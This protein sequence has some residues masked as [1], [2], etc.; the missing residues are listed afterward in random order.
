MGKIIEKIKKSV[1]IKRT[2][3]VIF[4]IAI[5]VLFIALTLWINSLNLN[6]IDFTSEKLYTL[7]ET[8]KE[9]V[10]N[11]QNDVN[12]YFIGYSENDAI[13]DL[14]KQ[15]HNEN[16]KINIE[17]TN[18][19][20]RPDLVEKYGIDNNSNG[21]IVEG[22][23]KSKI[24]ST[25]DF[26]TYDPKTYEQIDI[27]EEKLTNSILYVVAEKIPTVYFLEG[28]SE[29]NISVNMNYL[30]MYLANE[31]T[32]Y[33]TLNILTTGSIPEDCD[34][35]IIT[36]PEKD[37]D[38][39]AAN[40]ITEYINKGGNILWFNLA[41]TEN[42]ELPN[43]N[44]I[45][46]LYG[47]K[48]FEVGVINE[49]DNSRMMSGAPSIIIPNVGYNTITKNIPSALLINASKINFVAEEE[50]ESLKVTKNTLL[51]A[52]EGAF[53]RTNFNITSSSKQTGEEEGPFT[54]GA[55]MQKKIA[56]ANTETGESEKISKL[57]I[58]GEN[59]FIS[60]Y[61]LTQTSSYPMISYAYT[62]DLVIDSIAYLVDR[63]E[64]IVIRKDTNTVNYTATVEQ[65]NIIQG[66]IFGVPVV[67]ILIG[68]LVWQ[69]RRRKK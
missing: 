27:T 18:A 41:V 54:V 14:A 35:L 28:Y 37:F 26:Y 64:D 36:S 8:S 40:A 6:P 29:F 21:I 32:E 47:I 58:Y 12:I 61:T 56:E 55:E 4:M 38:D 42:K 1:L 52:S 33:K 46:S 25:N 16:S 59:L 7:T 63:Q 3:T 10:K 9:Q 49:T 65:D 44:K 43:V 51:E 68:I 11:V 20:S 67:I 2:T 66:I 19:T 31:V 53:F 13:I 48:P 50:L 15:Y 60:D 57:V 22:K 5:V 62:M 34:T 24:L 45:L 69:H 30:S 23:E 17:V 39:M